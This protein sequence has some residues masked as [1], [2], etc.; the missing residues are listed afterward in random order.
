MQITRTEEHGLRLVTRLAAEGGQLSVGEMAA[1]EQIPEPTVAKV[2]LAL[3]RAGLVR[4]VRGR[5]GG[6]RLA[7]RA[8]E[9]S[10][11]QVL[12]A[13]GQPLF[14]GRFCKSLDSES[15]V[16]CPHDAGCGIRPVWEHIQSLIL[17]TLERT[18]LADLL[19]GEESVREHVGEV[20][21]NEL[22][23]RRRILPVLA[24]DERMA[25]QASGMKET[26]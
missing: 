9:I 24:S 7:A 1:I 15:D 8:G 12:E 18:T 3:R 17:N 25:R 11:R 10:V 6:Y 13:L 2:L 4:A 19:G 26:G 16:S 20:L 14:E 21:G 5:N 22:D 23:R